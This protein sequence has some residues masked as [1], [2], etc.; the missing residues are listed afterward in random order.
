MGMV[1]E[2]GTGTIPRDCIVETA[3]ARGIADLHDYV[4]V[5]HVSGGLSTLRFLYYEQGREKWQGPPVDV[6]WFDEEPPKDVYDE[7]LARTI[8]TGGM[9]FLTFTPLQGMSD[10]VLQFLEHKTAE[11]SDTNMT[12]EDAEH[13]PPAER[14]KIIASFALHEREARARGT[15]MLGSGRIFPVP[16][17]D[18]VIDPIR[19]PAHWTFIGGLDFGWDHPFAAVCMAHDTDNDCVYVIKCYSAREQTP[20]QHAGAIR[21]WGDWL[22]WAWPHDGNNSEKGSGDQL[23]PQYTAQGLYMLPEKASHPNGG[24]GVEVGLLDML[25]RMLSGRFKVFS[26]LTPWLDQFRLYH[27]KDGKVV[28]T[29][30]DLL[31]ATRYACMMIR[32]A[33]LHPNALQ[34]VKEERGKPQHEFDHQPYDEA[35]RVV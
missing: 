33:T 11:R 23:T 29:R 13:I 26:H 5:R 30:D 19:I 7:G 35:W 3:P 24:I 25:D 16:E 12:I 32:Y 9:A 6:V 2:Q 10:V 31:D 20:I 27:R 21:L 17:E 28:K 8:A 4:K 22:P 18:I 15:P 14:A 34:R 1:G